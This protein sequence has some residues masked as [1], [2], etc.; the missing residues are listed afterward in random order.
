MKNKQFKKKYTLVFFLCI[1]DGSDVLETIECD[2]WFEIT[3]EGI[4]YCIN[5]KE[6]NVTC[7]L[8]SNLRRAIQN[9]G[10]P[11]DSGEITHEK[12]PEGYN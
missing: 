6:D 12:A 3:E 11:K 7:Y 2:E 5:E 4:I 8:K 9:Y 10:I 1:K